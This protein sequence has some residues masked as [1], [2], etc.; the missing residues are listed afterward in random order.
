[1]FAHFW[2]LKT[3]TQLKLVKKMIEDKCE[4]ILLWTMTIKLTRTTKTMDFLAYWLQR[5]I[6][7]LLCC[8]GAVCNAKKIF[9]FD[10]NWTI[11]NFNDENWTILKLI[12]L[13]L[14]R[15]FEEISSPFYNK[16]LEKENSAAHW[17]RYAL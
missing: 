14:Q 12:H 1:M 9:W 10:E 4:D 17:L 15:I 6:V 3:N 7:K 11:L 8:K 16:V 13:N 2:R 5:K